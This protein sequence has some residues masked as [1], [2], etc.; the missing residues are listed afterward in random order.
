MKNINKQNSTTNNNLVSIEIQ[1]YTLRDDYKLMVQ[2]TDGKTSESG[3]SIKKNYNE[4][5]IAGYYETEE[6]MM[7][8]ATETYN[9]M[10]KG[11]QAEVKEAYSEMMKGLQIE[12]EEAYGE[13]MK[14]LQT[15]VEEAYIEMINN[16]D[17]ANLLRLKTNNN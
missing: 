14:G 2:N 7:A 9:E 8:D 5:L 17:S 13:M 11:L 3:N 15:E 4:N 12:V 16:A 1:G 6:E 10:T